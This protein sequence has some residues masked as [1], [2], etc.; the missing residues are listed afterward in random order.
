MNNR[1]QFEFAVQLGRM[2]IP[3]IGHH[4]I[5]DQMI[6]AFKNRCLQVLGSINVLTSLRDPLTYAERKMLLEKKYPELP[7]EGIP[8]FPGDNVT[9]LETLDRAIRKHY[10]GPLEKV[11]FYT[12]CAEDVK[13][14]LM[15][16]RSCHIVNRYDGISSPK[17]SG[18][19]VRTLLL[20]A[21]KTR[22]KEA[23]KDAIRPLVD[24]LLVDDIVDLYWGKIEYMKEDALELIRH[25]V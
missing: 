11:V 22:D 25:I 1:D 24:P 17:I 3:H 7:I 14:L 10:T 6:E 21:Y 15:D 4:N 16:K 8:D 12:G 23:M 2:S 20:G 18:T 9:W 13:E 5:Q 19:E